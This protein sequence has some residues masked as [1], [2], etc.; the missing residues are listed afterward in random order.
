MSGTAE[1]QVIWD[2]VV[3][4]LL[5]AYIIGNISAKKSKYIHVCQSYSKSQVGRFW[6]T[7]QFRIANATFAHTPLLSI[8]HPKFGDVSVKLDRWA[9]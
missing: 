5:I 7:V 8:F 4:R 9:V 3:K 6:D 1:A 2:G